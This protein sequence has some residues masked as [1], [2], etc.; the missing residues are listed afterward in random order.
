MKNL[1]KKSDNL[2][3]KTFRF[4]KSN[5]WLFTKVCI[6]VIL[7]SA[8][9]KS[10][11]LTHTN[12]S[13]VALILYVVGIYVMLALI[14]LNFNKTQEEKLKISDIYK[15]SSSRF[16]PF[17]AVSL[18]Q[19]AMSLPLII[20]AA[21]IALSIGLGIAPAFVIVGLALMAIS[22]VLLVWYSMA[23]LIIVEQSNVTSF[24]A[25]AKSKRL[26]KGSFWWLITRYIAFSLLV[27]V[28]SG[29]IIN[30]ITRF[31][32]FSDNWFI[33]GAIDGI[34]LTL[35]LSV[36]TIFAYNLYED[37]KKRGKRPS[38]KKN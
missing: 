27:G 30:L 37:L 16:F 18:M 20:G 17:L 29:L 3:L 24:S 19:S 15:R 9:I 5:F 28:F 13:D 7:V 26:I 10:Y 32:I 33:K 35:V 31:S 4:Y 1:K 11:D 6:S 25:L 36:L 2:F 23:G 12:S 8:I 34:L 38:K 21:M 14:W 22:C